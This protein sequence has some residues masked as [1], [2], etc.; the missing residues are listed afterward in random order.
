MS[1]IKWTLDVVRS[2]CI[3]DGGCWIW[4]GAKVNGYP[5]ATMYGR[6]GQMVRKWVFTEFTGSAI[7]PKM[8]IVSSC[9][10]KDCVN[11]AHLRLMTTSD[12]LRRSYATGAR[13]TRNEY[14]ARVK[15]LQEQG[16]T[17]MDFDKAQELRNRVELGECGK[18]LAKDF[19]VTWAHARKILRGRS[20]RTEHIGASVFTWRPR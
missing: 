16:R 10:R 14:H 4:Q 6:G 5:Q 19:G 13:C 17:V 7:G 20:W 18:K 1:T 11:P 3:D 9:R 15:R 2:R 12:V 8:K